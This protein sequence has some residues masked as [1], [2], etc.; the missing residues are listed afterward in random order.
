MDDS[1]LVSLERAERSLP[2]Q[3][4]PGQLQQDDPHP[5]TYP[6]HQYVPGLP[7]GRPFSEEKTMRT[8]SMLALTGCL[9]WSVVPAQAA[10]QP[11][12]TGERVRYR[13]FYQGE[14]SVNIQA[15]LN[16]NAS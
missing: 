2:I 5:I 16:H 1:G 3:R 12:K 14:G 11:V 7:S 15:W 10:F 4:R 13:L 6:D 8:R 9:L